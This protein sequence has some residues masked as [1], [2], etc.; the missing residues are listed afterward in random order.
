[1]GVTVYCGCVWGKDFQAKGAASAK[2]LRS[3]VL[4][5]FRAGSWLAGMLWLVDKRRQQEGG[6]A[7]RGLWGDRA[8]GADATG[9]PCPYRLSAPQ[10]DA[11]QWLLTC[12]VPSEIFSGHRSKPRVQQGSP[13]EPESRLTHLDMAESPR[14]QKAPSPRQARMGVTLWRS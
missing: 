9:R 7:M 14:A 3:L 4:G 10:C 5:M 2:A 6:G 1:M 13:E 11:C 12:R 8:G